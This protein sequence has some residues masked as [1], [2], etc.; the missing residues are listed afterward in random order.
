VYKYGGLVLQVEG[1]CMRL[2]TSPCKKK[3]VENRVRKKNLRRGQGSYLGC[4]AT[5]CDDVDDFIG[6][7]AKFWI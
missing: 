7:L 5:D 3:F 1:L 6:L 4:G 2:T